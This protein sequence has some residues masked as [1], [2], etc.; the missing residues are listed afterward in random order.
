M[1]DSQKRFM[2]KMTSNAVWPVAASNIFYFNNTETANEVTRVARIAL[3]KMMKQM[4]D[5]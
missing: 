4:H 2:E 5:R 1:K 3:L